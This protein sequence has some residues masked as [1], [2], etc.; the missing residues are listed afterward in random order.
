MVCGCSS[1]AVVGFDIRDHLAAVA[2]LKAGLPSLIG[3]V[4][5]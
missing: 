1:D 5:L 4:V 3:L 2:G